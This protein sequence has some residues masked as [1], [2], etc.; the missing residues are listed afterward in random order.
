M[1]QK[2]L[3]KNF[4]ESKVIAVVGVSRKKDIPAN[5]IFEKFRKAGYNTYPINPNAEEIGGAKCY[6]SIT[7]LPEHPDGVLLA[8]TPDV[9]EQVARECIAVGVKNVW[10]HRGIGNG[11]YSEKA[12]SIFKES[13]IQAI[14]NGCPMMFIKP[15]DPFHRIFKWFK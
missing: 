12:E 2:D 1:L 14:T 10:M 6:P 5:G 4:L 13:G 15:V 9:S 3:I 8:G 7:D 11:S